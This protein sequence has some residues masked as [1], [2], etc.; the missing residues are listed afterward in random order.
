MQIQ[1]YTYNSIVFTP[2]FLDTFLVRGKECGVMNI[3]MNPRRVK[4]HYWLYF[5][6]EETEKRG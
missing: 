6:N 5:T 3:H 2:G 1:D 4:N